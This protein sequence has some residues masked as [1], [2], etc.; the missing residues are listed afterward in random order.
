MPFPSKKD[1]QNPEWLAAKATQLA[2][3]KT[4]VPANYPAEIKVKLNDLI[5][6][7]LKRGEV[8]NAP[9]GSI[10]DAVKAAYEIP[11]KKEGDTRLGPLKPL[12]PPSQVKGQVVVPDSVPLARTHIPF[13]M[14]AF[15]EN[16]LIADE[17]YKVDDSRE[18]EDRLN[19]EFARA[20]PDIQVSPK[21]SFWLDVIGWQSPAILYLILNFKKIVAKVKETFGGLFGKKADKKEE[22]KA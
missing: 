14:G 20:Y 10:S 9:T 17:K 6:A 1:F 18:T 4:P 22:V 16:R 12:P 13:R 7:E 5:L 15:F 2:G 8:P 21:V 11:I 3:S 19:E